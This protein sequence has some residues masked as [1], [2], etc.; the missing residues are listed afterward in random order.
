MYQRAARTLWSLMTTSPDSPVSGRRPNLRVRVALAVLL[1]AGIVASVAD[2]RLRFRDASGSPSG[3]ARFTEHVVRL[4]AANRY[5]AA[6]TLL[7]PAHRDLVS[8]SAYARC[9]SLSPIPG[10]LA[11]VRVLSVASGRVRVAG[12]DAALPGASV[13]VRLV[14]TGLARVVVTHTFHAVRAD[15]R[16][17]WI[18]PPSRYRL[19]LRGSCPGAPPAYRGSAGP[20][21]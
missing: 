5:A 7:Y 18:L 21:A 12:E 3:A 15:G 14:I 8:R 11:S 19:Y 10:R 20:A 6:W 13:Q 4:V 1:C 16:W 17:T 2:A 9:E